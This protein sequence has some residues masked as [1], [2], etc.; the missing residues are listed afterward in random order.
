VIVIDQYGMPADIMMYV[1]LARPAQVFA[2]RLTDGRI[3][4]FLQVDTMAMGA[5]VA[6]DLQQRLAES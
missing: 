6:P 3:V 1:G 2:T 5:N 4:T